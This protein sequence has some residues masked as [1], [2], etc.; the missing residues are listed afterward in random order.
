[1]S[2]IYLLD[3]NTI[4]EPIKKT[5]NQQV[6]EKIVMEMQEIEEKAKTF[7]ITNI[8]ELRDNILRRYL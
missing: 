6:L 5:P 7:V 2:L 4:S 3:T 1:M 8:D